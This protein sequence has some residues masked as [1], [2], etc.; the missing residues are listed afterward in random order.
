MLIKNC[1]S[2]DI[3]F[4]WK[5]KLI[6]GYAWVNDCLKNKFNKKI[7]SYKKD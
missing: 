7:L 2:F 5:T 3:A 4:A 1:Y 6:V